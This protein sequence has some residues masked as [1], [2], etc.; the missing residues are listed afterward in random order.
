ML[1]AIKVRLLQ[2]LALYVPGAWSI[3]VWL[4][5]WRGMR[6]GHDVFIGTDAMIETEHPERVWI[7][8]RVTIGA[9]CTIIAHFRGAR[10][11]VTIEDDVFIGPG[12]IILPGVI[13]RRGAVVSAGSVVTSAV[14][15]MT[16]VQGNPARAVARCG[17]PLSS[18][19][20]ASEFYR[21]LRPL[22]SPQRI[23]GQ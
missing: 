4:H 14:P 16:V 2:V 11:G 10:S 12:A 13:I 22:N 9:R 8:S 20:P 1:R 19:T 7:G 23:G 17:I 21:K 3:R 15:E 5:R 6:V 18:R